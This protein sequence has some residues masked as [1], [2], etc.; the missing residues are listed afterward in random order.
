M[1]TYTVDYIWGEDSIIVASVREIPGCHTQGKTLKQARE[2]IREAM[3][4]FGID[5]SKVQLT[6][7]WP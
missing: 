2:R 5:C 7:F 6:E 3:A 1:K 4:L